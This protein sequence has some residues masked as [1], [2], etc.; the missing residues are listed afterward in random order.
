MKCLDCWSFGAVSSCS[1]LQVQQRWCRSLVNILHKVNGGH[2]QDRLTCM[3]NR[4]ANDLLVFYAY[5]KRT[6]STHM[7]SLFCDD[8]QLQH[9][10]GRQHV[11]DPC[12]S[13]L[14]ACGFGAVCC[15]K[16]FAGHA[17]MGVKHRCQKAIR[18][19]LCSSST[20]YLHLKH[21]MEYQLTKAVK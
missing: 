2:I 7:A 6:V 15:C 9:A 19:P 1:L 18:C 20:L 13:A 8:T 16:A 14:V 12:A 11:A 5:A 21:L 3:V 10:P 17:W 4:S